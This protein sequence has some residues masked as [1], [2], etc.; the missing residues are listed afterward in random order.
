MGTD[1]HLKNIDKVTG[2]YSDYIIPTNFGT[3][4]KSIIDN[5]IKNSKNPGAYNMSFGGGM[6]KGGIPLFGM[7]DEYLNRLITSTDLSTNFLIEKGTKLQ[8]VKGLTDKKIIETD[9]KINLELDA[10]KQNQLK[11]YKEQLK[12]H[13]AKV[14][15]EIDK[16]ENKKI[17]MSSHNTVL[18]NN[19]FAIQEAR[20]NNINNEDPT[21]KDAYE[22]SS[23]INQDLIAMAILDLPQTPP[24]GETGANQAYNG[25]NSENNIFQVA[26]SLFSE[27]SKLSPFNIRKYSGEEDLAKLKNAKLY[28]KGTLEK[29]D[30]GEFLTSLPNDPRLPIPP[31]KPN[32]GQGSGQVGGRASFGFI[33]GQNTQTTDIYRIM[34]DSAELEEKRS[35]AKL[36]Q[37]I[38]SRFGVFGG[39]YSKGFVPN[40]SPNES[41]F[42]PF[43]REQ[44]DIN[45]GVGGARPWDAPYLIPNF[46]SGNRIE[47]IV[48]NTGEEIAKINRKPSVLTRDMSRMRNASSGFIPNFAETES[49]NQE[50]IDAIRELLRIIALLESTI[51]QQKNTESSSQTQTSEMNVNINS[52]VSGSVDTASETFGKEMQSWLLTMVND[53][54]EKVKQQF[55]ADARSRANLA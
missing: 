28:G 9:G 41:L 12:T 10:N 52:I 17:K 8:G 24:P 36:R 43:Q 18:L 54:I 2:A 32:P 31:P 34:P 46:N 35:N 16:N 15:E 33:G 26:N 50:L 21:I 40:F 30:S 11:I 25:P 27:L 29:F 20:K 4:S 55:S 47:P 7:S 14:Q 3:K 51:S 42:N 38:A 39:I 22:S 1:W 53:Q 23:K 5:L 6:A 19:L 13:S 37:A 49:G 45:A 44:K 48:V